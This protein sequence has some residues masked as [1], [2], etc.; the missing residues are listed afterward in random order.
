MGGTEDRGEKPVPVPFCPPQT[1]H[2]LTR[3]RDRTFEVGG[4]WIVACDIT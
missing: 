3:D 4:R 2:G 1:T